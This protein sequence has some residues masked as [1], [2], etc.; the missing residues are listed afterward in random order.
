ML[1]RIE[2]YLLAPLL[3]WQGRIARASIPRLPEPPG[4]RTGSAGEG[5]PLRLLVIGDSA[6]AGVGANHQDEALLG[7]LVRDLC[8]DFAVHWKLE[9]KTG[10]TTELILRRV[11]KLGGGPYDIAV[12]SLGVNDITAGLSLKKWLE[13][14]A[15]LRDSLREVHAVRQIYVSGLPPVGEFP[16]IPNPLRWYLGQRATVFNE[17]LRRAIANDENASFM[18]LRFAKDHGLLA[19][20]GFHPGSQIYEQWASAIS[21][22]VTRDRPSLAG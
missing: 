9:A 6:A 11:K 18:N 15:A 16:A 5:P 13:Q 10:A 21:A 17:A 19:E 12:T 3:F 14:Q 8:K 22:A 20:D 7:Y 4:P 2:F 1:H